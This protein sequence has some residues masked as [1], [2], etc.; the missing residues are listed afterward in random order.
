M[1]YHH[2]VV[3]WYYLQLGRHPSCPRGAQPFLRF[4][5]LVRRIT[6]RSVCVR[7]RVGQCK[8]YQNTRSKVRRA[9]GSGAVRDRGNP[10]WVLNAER[11]WTVLDDGGGYG[12][13]DK[14]SRFRYWREF[15]YK[16]RLMI[17]TMV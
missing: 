6:D 15:S 10:E 7:I 3:R 13:W 14:V 8:T 4:Y 17:G 9:S 11:D 2:V 1:Q 12:M 16:E 5:A